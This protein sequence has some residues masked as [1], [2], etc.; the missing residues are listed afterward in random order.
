M[1]GEM[2]KPIFSGNESK[3]M[4]E[5]INSALSIE[6]LRDALYVVC[7]KLQE[8]ESRLEK[9]L[10]WNVENQSECSSSEST[11]REMLD[12]LDCEEWSCSGIDCSN[13]QIIKCQKSEKAIRRLIETHITEE[14]LFEIKTQEYER[15]LKDGRAEVDKIKNEK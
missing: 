4:W 1:E 14:E 10:G 5:S 13:E 2:M 11:K 6:D 12:F 15:G 7:C 8:L 9:E 3:E